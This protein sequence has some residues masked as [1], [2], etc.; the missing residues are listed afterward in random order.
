MK[1]ITFQWVKKKIRQ[2]PERFGSDEGTAD[3][4][5]SYLE[6]NNPGCSVS[7]ETVKTITTIAR[8]RR[9]FLELHP[10]FDLRTQKN[11]GG[12]K[13]PDE[14]VEMVAQQML[15]KGGPLQKQCANELRRFIFKA[16]KEE[17]EKAG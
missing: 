1:D 10:E 14:V 15:N 2:N 6:A 3:L 17:E 11:N 13:R 9:K 8:Q 7:K 16:V 5:A 4:I 12:H